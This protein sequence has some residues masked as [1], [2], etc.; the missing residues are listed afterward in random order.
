MAQCQKFSFSRGN[1]IIYAWSVQGRVKR[2]FVLGVLASC[3]VYLSS[4]RWNVRSTELSILHEC[5]QYAP[6]LFDLS[7]NTQLKMINEFSNTAILP[8]SHVHS[9]CVEGCDSLY[10]VFIRSQVK[11][12]ERWGSYNAIG[13]LNMSHLDLVFEKDATD[14]DEIWKMSQRCNARCIFQQL[15]ATVNKTHHV[16]GMTAGRALW[17]KKFL[18]LEDHRDVRVF[19]NKRRTCTV[20]IKKGGGIYVAC[21]DLLYNSI[22]SSGNDFS[23][24]PIVPSFTKRVERGVRNVVPIVNAYFES[25]GSSSETVWLLDAMGSPASTPIMFLQY[26]TIDS[27]TLGSNEANANTP[28]IL[29]GCENLKGWRAN[30]PVLQISGK[31]WIAIVHKRVDLPQRTAENALGR[32]YINLAVLFK[33]DHVDG[34]P[35][36]CV[37]NTIEKNMLLS[38]PHLAF[39]YVLGLVNVRVFKRTNLG[40][41]YRFVLTGAIDDFMPIFHS[42][43]LFV[44][45]KL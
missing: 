25:I 31:L 26:L 12:K 9:G 17:P 3:F 27:S 35:R 24:L 7:D 32:E 38:K 16:Y 14:V 21:F 8:V 33:S 29:K 20:S 39:V 13:V 11:H 44:S 28:Y 5:G 6:L 15:M 4:L 2:A 42:F 41:I 18:L 40:T 43:D 22:P 34:P 19:Y 45:N 23:G 1:P 36:Q 10:F 30:T 37:G